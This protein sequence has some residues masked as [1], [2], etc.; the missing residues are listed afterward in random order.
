VIRR[1]RIPYLSEGSSAAPVRILAISDEPNE[2]LRHEIN[3]AAV[4]RIDAILGAGDLEPDYLAMLGDAF[5]V[6]LLYVLGNHDRGLN[7]HATSIALP[8]PMRD[9]VAETIAGVEV[10]GFSWP[11]ERSGRPARD[12]W[13]AWRQV[14]RTGLRPRDARVPRIILSHVPP[15]GAGDDPADPYH[16]GFR[17]YRW[18][19]GRVAPRLWLHGHT[20]VATQRSSEVLRDG[21]QLINVTGGV[22]LELLPAAQRAPLAA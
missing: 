22:L 5:H 8:E 14:L 6:P 13:G 10:V 11:G 19:L 7:W 1:I 9:G 12:E 18:L 15:E 21:T 17:A 4:G 16:R 3:R 20:T 2:G